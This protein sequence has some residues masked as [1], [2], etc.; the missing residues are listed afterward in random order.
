MSRSVF[1]YPEDMEVIHAFLA[2]KSLQHN[3]DSRVLSSGGTLKLDDVVVASYDSAGAL[4]VMLSGPWPHSSQRVMNV[5]AE[6]L[7]VTDCAFRYER[8]DEGALI[9]L[10]GD[11]V[12]GQGEPF[13]MLGGLG[14]AAYR[15]ALKREGV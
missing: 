6:L 10:A 12:V 5:L 14:V 4:Q 8:T 1:P 2:G 11:R 3:S 15:A 7:G 13:V 9:W